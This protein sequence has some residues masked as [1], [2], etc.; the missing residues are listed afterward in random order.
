[1]HELQSLGLYQ[2]MENFADEVG[3]NQDQHVQAALEW[4]QERDAGFQAYI[5]QLEAVEKRL[6][7]QLEGSEARAKRLAG[8]TVKHLEIMRGLEAEKID[9]AEK[10]YKA[11][12]TINHRNNQLIAM[13]ELVI[14]NNRLRQKGE[15]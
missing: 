10:L 4:V 1:M 8:D 9:L 14:E 3:S 7:E 15:K 11:Q 6:R 13:T 2:I 5:D 12:N